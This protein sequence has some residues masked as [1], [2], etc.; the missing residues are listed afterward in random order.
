M[1]RFIAEA[2]SRYY[3]LVLNVGFGRKLQC[4]C[5]FNNFHE[6]VHF[7]PPLKICFYYEPKSNYNFIN[8]ILKGH[9]I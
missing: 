9:F 3:I 8:T 7:K 1:G 2:R 5:H 4:I 6:L